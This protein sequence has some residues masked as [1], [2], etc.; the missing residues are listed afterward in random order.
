METNNKENE[1][2]DTLTL[3]TPSPPKR[4]NK[5][6]HDKVGEPLG[7]PG[8]LTPRRKKRR[9]SIPGKSILKS[10]MDPN[11]DP[12]DANENKTDA[13][14]SDNTVTLNLAFEEAKEPT[15]GK[16]KS[17]KSL[18]RRV[19]FAATAHVRLF[20]KEA[21]D[22]KI[23][24]TPKPTRTT[25]FFSGADSPP[26]FSAQLDA[27]DGGTVSGN[28]TGNLFQI[29]DLSSVQH[30]NSNAFQLRL[31]LD[32][33][34]KPADLT[35][36]SDTESE[37]SQRSFDINLKGY[38]TDSTESDVDSLL[39]SG[40]KLAA[41]IPA[42]S[43]SISKEDDHTTT[44]A[45]NNPVPAAPR[46]FSL[47][48]RR[49]STGSAWDEGESMELVSS[50]DDIKNDKRNVNPLADVGFAVSIDEKKDEEE[51]PSAQVV[52]WGAAI[53]GAAAA[54][55]RA[56]MGLFGLRS[57]A[58]GGSPV[59]GFKRGAR[60]PFVSGAGLVF[61][62]DDDERNAE[63]EEGGVTM[64]VTKCVGGIQGIDDVEDD[65][66]EEEEE[67]MELTRAVGGIRGVLGV[68]GDEGDE[69]EED[70]DD[71]E[72]EM[73][74]MTM[75]LTKAV[76]GIKGLLKKLTFDKVEDE[77]EEDQ[78]EQEEMTMDVT[79]VVGGIRENKMSEQL[80]AVK[81]VT[82]IKARIPTPRKSSTPIPTT[83]TH[84]TSLQ[85][86]TVSTP[87]RSTPRIPKPFSASGTPTKVTP[88][89]PTKVTPRTPTKVTPGTRQPVGLYPFEQL[90]TV[91]QPS[92]ATGE[93]ASRTRR[94]T[95]VTAEAEEFDSKK[96]L[97][98]LA[99]RRRSIASVISYQ[100]SPSISRVLQSPERTPKRTPKR[101]GVLEFLDTP[102][103]G[104]P[105]E[106]EEVTREALISSKTP[107]KPAAVLTP[108]PA[109][110]RTV[111]STGV[112]ELL[113]DGHH[114]DST[115]G[116]A[117]AQC[118]NEGLSGLGGDNFYGRADYHEEE[119]DHDN[120]APTLSD[121][122][123]AAA[124][125][126][127]ELEL[128][129]FCCQELSRYIEEG[130]AAV[131]KI[132]EDVGQNNPHFFHEYLDG[133]ADLREFME[134]RFKL[135]K[136]HSRLSA[137]ENWY[138]WRDKLVT[139]MNELLKKNLAHLQRDK[140][141]V[142]QFS[143]QLEE[144]IPEVENYHAELTKREEEIAKCDKEQL[145]S[146]EEAIEEQKEQL[147][148]F[149]KELQTLEAEEAEL[150]AKVA[151]TE[152]EKMEILAAIEKAHAICE[153]A[154]CVTKEDLDKARNEYS[155]L[156]KMHGWV[157]IR[158]STR[159]V[160][161]VFDDAV[162]VRIDPTKVKERESE[163]AAEVE[164]VDELKIGK[165]G[166]FLAGIKAMKPEWHV[167][168]ILQDIGCYWNKVTLLRDELWRLSLKHSLD[169]SVSLETN[170]LTAHV[171]FFS[172]AA[173][174]KVHIELIFGEEDV[175]VYPTLK[176][177]RSKVE[178]VYGEVKEEAVSNVVKKALEKGGYEALREMCAE[179]VATM[180]K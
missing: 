89:T 9:S 141:Y 115:S 147:T 169:L 133:S 99:G 58:A 73:G 91:T 14:T 80:V 95:L 156:T 41:S 78:A 165:F 144:V 180:K 32:G 90:A 167:R 127:P 24:G 86:P 30:R 134:Q 60:N 28:L 168:E 81:V 22:W 40:R 75:E 83:P 68:S 102:K 107:T 34:S 85:T 135:I 170:E 130:K 93:V 25:T 103:G 88:R 121:C 82:P 87:K 100:P 23:N 172:Y 171:T 57:P 21:E 20:D 145:Q 137:K 27:S 154:K 47:A 50:D 19:S 139:D 39:G 126:M 48:T 49:E 13:E 62:M 55:A 118:V 66:E 94:A 166:I 138:D 159:Q 119:R 151:K 54:T 67:E 153:E 123:T 31:S 114:T 37:K 129:Q 142:N 149:G 38:H 7:K 45:D 179:L 157:P 61:G 131:Q 120:A 84:A 136:T 63:D 160:E 36:T 6:T 10:L 18:G 97:E 164:L 74:A 33:N 177:L 98:A 155:R 146:L 162:R 161:F 113:A 11:Y 173:R 3:R 16:R 178:V 77:D 51:G 17:R 79:K 148:I 53:A 43:P 143:E 111:E 150:K 106:K 65:E 92:L 105:E 140:K 72:E 117:A 110:A 122:V 71:E 112:T 128:Y 124:C 69:L 125:S 175:R 108:V 174:T 176:N 70:E 52:G 8:N 96:T 104:K 46:R 12:L 35:I 15:Q 76:G 101:G 158:V 132:E 109:P 1:N 64:D 163:G 44:T 152:E 116:L 26:D 59:F 2:N 56:G 29:P 4:H 5:R 42:E